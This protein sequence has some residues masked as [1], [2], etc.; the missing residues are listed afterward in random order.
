MSFSFSLSISLF[1][2]LFSSLSLSLLQKK[3]KNYTYINWYQ[4]MTKNFSCS[5]I[6][7]FFYYSLILQDHH[8][9]NFYSLMTK[10]EQCWFKEA[11]IFI[12]K[13]WKWL[14]MYK[15]E[16]K[17]MTFDHDFCYSFSFSS[18]LFFKEGRERGKRI[19]NVVV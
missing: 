5:F 2:S 1:F 12:F 18:S 17:S 7:L 6:L 15:I 11:D 8:I 4:L 16:Q 14:C 13:V 3:I 9:L 10:L 19:T